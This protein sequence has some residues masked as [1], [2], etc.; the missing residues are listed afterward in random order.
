MYP[1]VSPR[2]L[3]TQKTS[4]LNAEGVSASDT[5]VIRKYQ[6]HITATFEKVGKAKIHF[7]RHFPLFMWKKR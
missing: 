7:H 5:V 2:G 6:Q 4:T 3:T 1:T